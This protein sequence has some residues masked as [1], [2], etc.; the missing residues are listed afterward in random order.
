MGFCAKMTSSEINALDGQARWP[1]EIHQA[2]AFCPVALPDTVQEKVPRNE[3][4]YLSTGT[5]VQKLQD[6]IAP[7]PILQ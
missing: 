4:E 2:G 3:I 7:V 5:K 6:N 1:P